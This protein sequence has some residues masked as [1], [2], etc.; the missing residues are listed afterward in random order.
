MLIFF[1]FFFKNKL[2]ALKNHKN[3]TVI[4]L[5]KYGNLEESMQ[6]N[7]EEIEQQTND[8]LKKSKICFIL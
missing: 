2:S 3:S 4:L 8:S 7:L 6:I 5:K 1:N